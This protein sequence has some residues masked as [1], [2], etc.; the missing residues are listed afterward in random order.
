[1]A[2]GN[3][4]ENHG[5]QQGVRAHVRATGKALKVDDRHT[6]STSII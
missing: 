1:M 4:V 6:G 2:G 5:V 3:T